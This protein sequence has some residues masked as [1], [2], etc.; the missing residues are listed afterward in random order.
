[1][2]SPKGPAH[3]IVSALC[4]FILYAVL[5]Y[6]GWHLLAR[7]NVISGEPSSGWVWLLAMRAIWSELD[8]FN[9]DLE[10]RQKASGTIG[11]W[12]PYRLSVV[13]N[14]TEAAAFSTIIFHLGWLSVVHATDYAAL[15]AGTMAG[16]VL[17]AVTQTAGRLRDHRWLAA[18]DDLGTGIVCGGFIPF[19]CWLW[20]DW[21]GHQPERLL[22]FSGMSICAALGAAVNLRRKQSERHHAR[23]DAPSA[24]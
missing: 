15:L 23:Q 20:L 1:M 10:A 11:F 2:P 7:Y 12:G 3:R 8:R 22:W 13:S 18:L 9:D 24:S 19:A 6:S 21:N 4:R 17:A 14:A 16:A 5:F